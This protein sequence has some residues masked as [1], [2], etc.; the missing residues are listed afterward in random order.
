MLNLICNKK[1]MYWTI[2]QKKCKLNIE[3]RYN[4]LKNKE[5]G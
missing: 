1:Y 5:H 2:S 4:L 3:L